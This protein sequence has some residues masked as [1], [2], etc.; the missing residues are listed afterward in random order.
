MPLHGHYLPGVQR[1]GMVI[2]VTEIIGLFTNNF[3]YTLLLFLR[4]S[5]LILPSPV[6]GRKTVPGIIKISFI[7]CLTFIFLLSFPAPAEG[8]AYDTLLEYVIICIK[9]LLFGLAIG[10]I[11]TLFFNLVYSAGQI[12]DMQIGFGIVSVYDIQNNSQVPVV[13]NLL[14]I[15]LLIVFFCVNGHLKLIAVL[16]ATFEKI[17]VGHILL[18]MDF[19]TVMLEVFSLTFI[20]AIMVAMPLLAAGLI[21]EIAMG[22]LIRAVPQMN[23][24]VIGIPVK[25][26]VGLF[27]LLISVSV[28]VSFSNTIFTE[29]F[30]SIEQVFNT[31]GVLK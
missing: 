7:C 6:F 14:N 12:I 24:F 17:P 28:F 20:L 1:K 9:E 3:D 31:F 27:V 25:I 26:I 21:L 23:M 15:V 18:S 22:V 2:K 16:H 30:Q 4:V 5:G 29:M 19:V 8:I 10:Y 11:T 13:G